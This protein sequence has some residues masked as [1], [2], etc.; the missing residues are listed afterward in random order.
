M[1]IAAGN[2]KSEI[3]SRVAAIDWPCVGEGL[4][5]HGCAKVS[6]LLQPRECVALAALY[7][8]EARFRSR[9]VMARHGF[10]SGEY[11]YFRYPLPQIVADLRTALYRPLANIAN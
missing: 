5:R 3:P 6:G 10:G 7:G 8:D 9:V 11:K 1:A 4:N 2:T